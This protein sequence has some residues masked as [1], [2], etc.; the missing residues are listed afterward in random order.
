MPQYYD[1]HCHVFNK[2]VLVRGLVGV[3][4]VLI[5]FADHE[6]LGSKSHQLESLIENLKT[7]TQPE[8]EDVFKVLD[9]AYN[10][11]FVI[12]PLMLDLTYA[13]DNDG[14]N[15]RKDKRYRRRINTVFVLIH[16]LIPLVKRKMKGES[17]EL[18]DQLRDQVKAFEDS[19]KVKSKEEVELFDDSNYE[20]QIN[21]LEALAD[22]YNYVKPF[23]CIDPR[24]EH[25]DGMNLVELINE[26]V[27]NGKF[28]GVKMYA[29]VGF[30][31]TDPALMGDGTKK[32]VYQFC[33][34]NNIPIT[35]HCS[36]SGFACLS[37]ELTVRGHMNLDNKIFAAPVL[38]HK[39]DTHFLGFKPDEAIHE[40][41]YALNHPKLWKLV[42]EK[43]PNLTIN[44]A[45][46]GGVGPLMEYVKYEIP[47]GKIKKRIFKEALEKLP[48]ADRKTIE[49]G[50]DKRLGK[51]HLKDNLT[52]NERQKV[53]IAMYKAGL[54]DNWAKAL[55]DIIR[56]PAYKNAYTDLS[57]F[58]DGD[59]IDVPGDGTNEKVFSVEHNLRH[60]KRSM[61][62][63][64][65]DYEKSKVLYG[66][67]YF[68]IRFFGSEMEQYLADFKAAFGADFDAIA[69]KHPEAFLKIS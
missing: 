56:N 50:F 31:P 8:S 40:R 38:S 60:F 68:L 2:N 61:Y 10:H 26:K 41:A 15:D 46:F 33:I 4:Q 55:F 47:E 59:L 32:G 30:S 12:T 57:C 34:E 20:L 44:F 49:A 29:P 13:D 25:K 9:E 22:K 58:S 65:N 7:L 18:M 6:D 39:F 63:K 54:I 5:E 16:E 62:D 3:A 14:R 21:E 11:D 19:F 69:S 17:R 36:D 37:K 66:S 52:L 27:V 48:E 45:H 23:F 43:F 42:L 51:M 1:I 24:R 53:W 67:D 28:I 35:V 64:F